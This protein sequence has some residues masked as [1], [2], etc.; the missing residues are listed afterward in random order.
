MMLLFYEFVSSGGRRYRFEWILQKKSC[1]HWGKIG[2]TM[3]CDEYVKE[4]HIG[5]M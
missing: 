2:R 5:F 1:E 3:K 4:W